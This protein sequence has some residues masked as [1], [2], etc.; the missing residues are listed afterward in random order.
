MKILGKLSFQDGNRC[1][2]HYSN[3]EHSMNWWHK[4]KEI[5]IVGMNEETG[6]IVFVECKWKDVSY[7]GA[8]QILSDLEDKS[9]FVRW[10]N[11]T[12]K[13]H[14]GIVAK[15]VEGKEKLRQREYLVFD[16]DDI[17]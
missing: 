3:T 14:F 10:N 8:E 4:D 12:R 13:E 6:K 2:K 16:L 9:S 1:L 11:E 5:D 17:D 15:K 7:E